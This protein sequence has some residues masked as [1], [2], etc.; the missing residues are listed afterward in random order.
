MRWKRGLCANA[1]RAAAAGLFL[2]VCLLTAGCVSPAGGPGFT[3]TPVPSPT[4]GAVTAPVPET[5]TP[6]PV[7][8]EPI[9]SPPATPKETPGGKPTVPVVSTEVPE[10][11]PTGT[12]EATETG[13]PE[14]SETPTAEP[15]PELTGLPEVSST[16]LP[17]PTGL[18][19]YDTLLRNGWQRAEDFF[20]ER[21]IFFSGKFDLTELSV[22]GERYEYR[23]HA[24]SDPEIMF[25]II[26][27][28]LSV[29]QFLEDLTQEKEDCLIVREDEGDYG[30]IYTEENRQV[31]GRVYAC[32]GNGKE[33]RMRVEFYGPVA[34]DIVP[35]GYGFYLR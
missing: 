25:L 29:Q 17:T 14:P 21:D 26:G 11:E 15:V 32:G 5:P 13:C 2:G 16:P 24:S 12:P 1:K 28:K 30:Y 10:R 4:K 19:E 31:N 33:Q 8:T 3:A 9:S 23:Y 7:V 6:L 27:E 18:P 20:G 34:A 35:E 22:S